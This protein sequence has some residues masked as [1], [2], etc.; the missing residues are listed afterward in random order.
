MLAV[1]QVSYLNPAELYGSPVF[2]SIFIPRK[3]TCRC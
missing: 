2:N 3:S 1:D